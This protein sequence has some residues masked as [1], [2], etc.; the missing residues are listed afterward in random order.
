[1]AGAL[2]FSLVVLVS[3]WAGYRLGYED[4]LYYGRIGA[5]PEGDVSRVRVD[6]VLRKAYALTSVMGTKEHPVE[7]WHERQFEELE[8]ALAEVGR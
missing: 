4:G 5:E 2:G 1:M 6:D 7:P 3:A 8:M